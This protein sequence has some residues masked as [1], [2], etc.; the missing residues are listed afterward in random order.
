MRNMSYPMAPFLYLASAIK[1]EVGLLIFHATRIT[2][3]A[4]AAR[5]VEGARG[6]GGND[7][8]SHS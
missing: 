6:N 3:I 2:D 8:R 7:P 1:A 4:T 5:L